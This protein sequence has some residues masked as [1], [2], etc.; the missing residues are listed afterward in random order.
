MFAVRGLKQAA[1]ELRE[2]YF[3]GLEA[4]Y[5]TYVNDKGSSILTNTEEMRRE[6]AALRAEGDVVLLFAFMEWRDQ[7]KEVL[8]REHSLASSELRDLGKNAA[9][10]NRTRGHPRN[11]KWRATKPVDVAGVMVPAIGFGVARSP[12]ASPALRRKQGRGKIYGRRS[13]PR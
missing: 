13:Q 6:M 11:L 3:P 5:Y 10:C 9:D 12:L 1:K 7:Q 8:R 2:E 4:P